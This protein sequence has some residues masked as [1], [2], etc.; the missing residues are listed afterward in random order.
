MSKARPPEQ[1]V[2]EISTLLEKHEIHNEILAIELAILVLRR[3]KTEIK[4]SYRGEINRLN[5]L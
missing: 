3:E 2:S 4:R 1:L 5:K